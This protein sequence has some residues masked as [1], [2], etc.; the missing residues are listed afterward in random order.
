MHRAGLQCVAEREHPQ[1]ARAGPAFRQERHRAPS[2]LQFRNAGHECRDI[3]LRLVHQ[4]TV[5]EQQCLA[6]DAARDAATD[7]RAEVIDLHHGDAFGLGQGSDRAGQRVLAALLQRRGQ[8]QRQGPVAV[9]RGDHVGHGRPALGQ[10][11]GLVEGD[12]RQR[13]GR[14][15][16]LGVLYQDAVPGGRTGPDHDGRGRREPQRAGAGDH[17]DRDRVQN[18][19]RDIPGGQVPNRKGQEGQ[20]KDHGDED[21]ADLVDQA[22]DGGFGSLRTLDHADDAREGRLRPDGRSPD[23]QQ[24]VDVDGS[25]GKV[26]SQLLVDRQ[27]FARQHRFVDAAAAFDQNTVGRYAL[28]WP[29]DNHVAAAKL[30]DRHIEVR[31]AAADPGHIRAQRHQ[32][33]DC[34]GG[35]A[36][37]PALEPLAKQDE[38][39]DQRGTLEIQRQSPVMIRRTRDQHP[40]AEAP[41]RRGADRHQQIHVAGERARGLPPRNVET[42]AKPELHRGCEGELDPAG[43]HEVVTQRVR[44]H[45]G[46]QRHRQR[47]RDQ[48][49]GQL[50]T[51]SPRARGI[52]AGVGLGGGAVHGLCRKA[53]ARDRRRKGRHV[54]R[55]FESDDVRALGREIDGHLGHA[56]NAPQRLL[57]AA[58]ARR[59]GHAAYV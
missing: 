53:S 6:R 34:D 30:C 3:D 7:H 22:L 20:R 21:C 11:P 46:Q 49:V 37:G 23:D 5:A 56:R 13:V 47:H 10:R 48:D 9:C 51:G 8:A 2:G 33:A 43:Q 36:L 31:P 54:G 28:A 15:Q 14:L 25:P 59:A 17:H 45:A 4:T 50:G 18:S 52:P 29:H 27:A 39:H 40:G 42:P 57:D 1:Q 55:A 24:A 44:D 58:G 32:G 12:N 16:R 26:R 38:G 19:C 41:G 35:A